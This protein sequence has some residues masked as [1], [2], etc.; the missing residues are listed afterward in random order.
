MKRHSGTN[1]YEPSVQ[2]SKVRLTPEQEADFIRCYPTMA[3]ERLC[4]RFGWRT[5][6]GPEEYASKLRARGVTI[7]NRPT[8]AEWA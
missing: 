5:R 3:M 6:R 7:P 4:A 8:H 2:R 1:V